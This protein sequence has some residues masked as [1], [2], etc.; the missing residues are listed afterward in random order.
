MCFNVSSH[1]SIN[2]SQDPATS[3][4]KPVIGCG[5]AHH[6][7]WNATLPFD[8][9]YTLSA[10]IA[11]HTQSCITPHSFRS[12]WLVEGVEIESNLVGNR[13]NFRVS[14]ASSQQAEGSWSWDVVDED[15]GQDVET[16]VGEMMHIVMMSVRVQ[17]RYDEAKASIK[18][19]LFHW[20]QGHQAGI[21]HCS[22]S[23]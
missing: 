23:F 7:A 13:R 6:N 3:Q 11:D 4:L 2:E 17:D 14:G 21:P 19:I 18:S 12:Q 5:S 8:G 15:L 1:H 16:D 9:E 20:I 10:C 22:V